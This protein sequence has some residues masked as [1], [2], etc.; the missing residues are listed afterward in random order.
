[1]SCHLFKKIL[2]SLPTL[3]LFIA[4]G[5]HNV[6]T[7]F[8]LL[9]HDLWLLHA[10]HLMFIYC[11][12]SILQ[13]WPVFYA[14]FSPARGALISHV[15]ST[16]RATHSFCKCFFCEVDC[17]YLHLC[18]E[19][20]TPVKMLAGHT[21]GQ[22]GMVREENKDGAGLQN[23]FPRPFS[24]PLATYGSGCSWP[25]AAWLCSVAF[26]AACF[27]EF[28]QLPL[29]SCTASASKSLWEHPSLTPSTNK[30]LL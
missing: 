8:A 19:Q 15:F 5:Q 12:Y 2:Q 3:L 13:C 16:S 29:K 4:P 9:D 11:S 26:E 27:Q 6:T 22:E 20:L 17:L 30:Y 18:W 7:V 14:L 10:I 24:Q 28:V 21:S 23:R 25:E 1:M